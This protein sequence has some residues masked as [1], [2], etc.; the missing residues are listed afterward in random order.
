MLVVC[1]LNKYN[2]EIQCNY[3]PGSERI[4]KDGNFSHG[5]FSSNA[6]FIK[7]LN[8]DTLDQLSPGN[9]PQS[10]KCKKVFIFEN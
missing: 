2:A 1:F 8:S 4:S 5:K 3:L 6:E 9:P 7:P 10:E